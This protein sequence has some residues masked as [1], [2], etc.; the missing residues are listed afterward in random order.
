MLVKNLDQIHIPKP[1]G[2]NKEPGWA[3]QA[4]SGSRLDETI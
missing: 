3:N 2:E 1:G 4:D